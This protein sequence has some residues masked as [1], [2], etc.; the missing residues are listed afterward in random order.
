MSS[1]SF[2]SSW[3]L[4]RQQKY[5]SCSHYYDRSYYHKEATKQANYKRT[6]RGVFLICKS[7]FWSASTYCSGSLIS[8][9]NPRCPSCDGNDIKKL[10][11]NSYQAEFRLL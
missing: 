6:D 9:P 4:Q 8:M 10:I 7:C 3:Q 1:K 2:S 5:I 11:L